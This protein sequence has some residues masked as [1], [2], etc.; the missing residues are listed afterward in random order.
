MCFNVL[1]TNGSE[2]NRSNGDGEVLMAAW[3]NVI[4]IV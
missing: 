1:F 4:V 2:F 3:H